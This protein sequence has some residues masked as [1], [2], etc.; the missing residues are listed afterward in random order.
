MKNKKG[1]TLI[2]LLAVIVILAI[3]ALI[4]TPI[5][6]NMIEDAR[7][8][9][10]VDS[11]YGYIE[12]IEYNNSMNMLNKDK[13]PMIKSGT[14]TEINGDVNVKG[15]KPT[16]GNVTI[17]NG[18]VTSATL[19]INGYEVKYN[20]E[21]AT[22]EGKE[23]TEIEEEQPEEV[24][25]KCKRA[26]TLHTEKCKQD[27]NYWYCK[28][29]G[30][31]LN[32][33]ITYGN[34]GKSG[35]LSS[36][37][38][39]DCDVNG[40]GTYD[41]QTERFYYVADLDSLTAVLVYYNN[42]TKGIADNAATSLIAYNE[43]GVGYNGPITGITNLPT[44]TQWKNVS[45]KNSKRQILSEVD[46]TSVGSGPNIYDLP[47]EYDYNGYAAR[48]LT[49]QEIEKACNINLNGPV[50][51]RIDNCK[52]LLENTKYSTEENGT[53]GYWLETPVSSQYERAWIILAN[54]TIDSNRFADIK[55]T[56]GVRPAIEVAKSEMEI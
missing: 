34:L 19:I 56:A 29:D 38:A 43:N 35:T 24:T 20:G 9:A 11:A 40:D 46:G 52:F 54:T 50:S 8:S 28:V 25:Y 27:D 12:S 55:I 49:S 42:T 7:K 44:T 2:E 47:T 53:N 30:Y 26:T 14:V 32:S 45:L 10:A 51:T 17:E 16:S 15:T 1:F 6:L 18:R 41:S 23:D 33:D 13:Y 48:F 37:D 39:Y 21:K 3:I 4:A 31:E 36:G 22:V 5:I